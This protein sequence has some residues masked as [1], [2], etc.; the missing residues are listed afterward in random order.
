MLLRTPVEHRPKHLQQR[1]C[2]LYDRSLCSCRLNLF[3]LAV[4]TSQHFEP[5]APSTSTRPILSA[6]LQKRTINSFSPVHT[7]S[8]SR[9]CSPPLPC[10]FGMVSSIFTAL[11]PNPSGKTA[12]IRSCILTFR[13]SNPI[14]R[15]KNLRG[16]SNFTLQEALVPAGLTPRRSLATAFLRNWLLELADAPIVLLIDEYDAPLTSGHCHKSKSSI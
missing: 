16:S 1:D 7:A 2:P 15:T 13:F 4:P 3:L 9:F 10:S 5:G 11:R 14:A 8:G 6:V 12:L